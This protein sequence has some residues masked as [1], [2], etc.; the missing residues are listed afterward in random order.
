MMA[1]PKVKKVYRNNQF[2][3]WG[4][5]IDIPGLKIHKLFRDDTHG[6]PEG[7]RETAERAMEV[8][9][10]FLADM[11]EARHLPPP[12]ERLALIGIENGILRKLLAEKKAEIERADTRAAKKAGKELEILSSK[13]EQAEATVER[14]RGEIGGRSGS[15]AQRNL[16]LLLQVERAE[17]KRLTKAALSGKKPSKR[18]AGLLESSAAEIRRLNGALGRSAASVEVIRAEA[19]AKE[20]AFE[21]EMEKLRR[22]IAMEAR[23][24]NDLA[25][26]LRSNGIDP[27]KLTEKK[28][29]PKPPPVLIAGEGSVDGCVKMAHDGSS[30]AAYYKKKNKSFQVSVHGESEALRKALAALEMLRGGSK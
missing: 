11:G 4:V 10:R 30:Y 6:G 18:E 15:A 12:D 16:E 23:R 27:L 7:S 1:V 5:K 19:G 2:G 14:L 29:L 3:A 22:S 26:L 9:E 8:A 24:Y 25:G 13:L 21:L 28:F 17:V 20:E